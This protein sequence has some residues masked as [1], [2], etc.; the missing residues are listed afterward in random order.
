M[1][2]MTNLGEERI[3][4]LKRMN[5]PNEVVGSDE[6]DIVR[7]IQNECALRLIVSALIIT[8]IFGFVLDLTH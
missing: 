5:G 2:T 6:I 7:E 8:I 4:L 1:S 3:N